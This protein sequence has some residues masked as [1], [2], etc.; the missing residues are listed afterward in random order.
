MLS[1]DPQ[2][3]VA[4][5]MFQDSTIKLYYE[6][7]HFCEDFQTASLLSFSGS[8][9]LAAGSVVRTVRPLECNIR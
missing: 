1:N 3:P 2:S 8:A 9:S 4:A 6:I 5:Q 7:D